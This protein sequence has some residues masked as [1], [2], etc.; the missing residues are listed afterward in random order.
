VGTLLWVLLGR[1]CTAKW[2]QWSQQSM[3]NSWIERARQERDA[4]AMELDKVLY[5]YDN[6]ETISNSTANDNDDD[7]DDDES[8][9]FL[10][11]AETVHAMARERTLD[12][13]EHVRK[14]ARRC[15][16][17]GYTGVNN[18]ENG[19][20]AIA[21]ECYDQ[22]LGAA[23]EIKRILE[24]NNSNNKALAAV[25]PLFGVPISVKESIGVTGF[26]STGGLACRL[27]KRKDEDALV[28]QVL[29]RHPQDG[30]GVIPLCTGNVPQLLMMAETANY[31][32]S[33]TRN[34]WDLTRT[35]GGVDRG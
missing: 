14:L 2:K 26:Y 25:S 1:T 28:V 10:T 15:R 33:R 22:A 20:N 12:P 19:V 31:I 21:E 35:V 17:Y 13:V 6:D 34:P 18:M 5:D 4:K 24:T 8:Y 30:G 16:K 29:R 7:D 27:A 3:Y 32:W 11:V 9:A 23:R